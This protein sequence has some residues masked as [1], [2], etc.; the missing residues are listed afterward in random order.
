MCVD[1]YH[2][3]SAFRTREAAAATQSMVQN[4]TA[5]AF[6]LPNRFLNGNGLGFRELDGSKSRETTPAV[7]V[8][9]GVVCL[10]VPV[11]LRPSMVY[12][13]N[14]VVIPCHS[15]VQLI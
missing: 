9:L 3:A 1:T 8:S 14:W 13:G 5:S 15:L 7:V 2:K 4:P 10:Y 12:L 6:G 11:G